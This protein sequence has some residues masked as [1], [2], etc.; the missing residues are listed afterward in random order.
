VCLKEVRET[1]YW[2]RLIIRSE[3]LAG[4]KLEDLTDEAT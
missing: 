4:K 1:R 3:L 2:L